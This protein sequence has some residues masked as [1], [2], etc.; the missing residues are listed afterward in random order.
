MEEL[1]FFMIS[2][3]EM[4]Q[5]YAPAMAPL[6]QRYL[7]EA[8]DGEMEVSDIFD[9]IANGRAQAFVYATRDASTVKIVIVAELVQYAKLNALNIVALAG[10]D[11][12]GL[13]DHH[14]ERFKGWAYMVGVRAIEG[15]VSERVARLIR[16]LGFSKQAVFARLDL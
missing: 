13:A 8:S 10:E 16:P 11:L 12:A 3:A 7:D 2:T 6:L 5:S 9:S 15:I 14:W 4:L 1:D